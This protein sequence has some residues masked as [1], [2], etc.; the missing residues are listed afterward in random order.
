METVPLPAPQNSTAALSL[1]EKGMLGHLEMSCFFAPSKP[2]HTPTS[3]FILVTDQKHSVF[4]N[5]WLS[6]KLCPCCPH[7]SHTAYGLFHTSAWWQWAARCAFVLLLGT[8]LNISLL[9]EHGLS[10]V[11]MSLTRVK[12]WHILNDINIKKRQRKLNNK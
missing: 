4:P 2:Q 5:R 6:F 3:V 12:P 9:E 10:V 1:A 7:V 11:S 8:V